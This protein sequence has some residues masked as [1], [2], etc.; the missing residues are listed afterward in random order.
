VSVEFLDEAAWR[1]SPRAH[2]AAVRKEILG[3][4][5]FTLLDAISAVLGAAIDRAAMSNAAHPRPSPRETAILS[6]AVRAFRAI[7]AASAVIGNGYALEAEPFTR[8]LLELFVSAKAIVDDDSGVEAKEWLT[9]NR[10]LGIGKRVRAAIP[11]GSVYGDL[12]Q[13]THGDPRVLRRALLKL[14]DGERTIQWGPAK[15]PQTE[16]Q[17]KHLALAAREFSVLLEE[18][19]FDRQPE[20]DVVDQALQRLIPAWRPDMDYDAIQSE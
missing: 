20:I 3:L 13:A 8:M 15:T 2:E 16:E 17:L 18:G 4:E 5:S 14:A 9:G 19:G 1:D 12:S 7:R 6:A 11:D 10:A